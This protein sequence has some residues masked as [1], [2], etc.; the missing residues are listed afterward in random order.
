MKKRNL[1]HKDHWAT[2]PHVYMQLDKEYHFDFDP[3]PLNHD[4]NLWDGTKVPWG[5]RNFINPPYNLIDKQAF[6]KKE[7]DESKLGKLCVM[8][9]P[10]STSTKLFHDLIVKNNADIKFVKGRI[11][12]IGTNDKGQRVNWHLI[13][14]ATDQKI[15]HKG[16]EIPLYIKNSG[17]HDSMIVLFGQ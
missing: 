16:K 2:P 13:N 9:L 6:V 12:F 10:V 15:K 8:I 17:Q 4:L 3:C 7:I 5:Q 14:E 1:N 11:P